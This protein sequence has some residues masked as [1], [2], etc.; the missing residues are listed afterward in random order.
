M[1]PRRSMDP[2]RESLLVAIHLT[3]QSGTWSFRLLDGRGFMWGDVAEWLL[4]AEFSNATLR[5]E[6]QVVVVDSKGAQ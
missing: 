2:R 5:V 3:V 4:G 1:P 6:P